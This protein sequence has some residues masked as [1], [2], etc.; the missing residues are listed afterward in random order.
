MA[1]CQP[2]DLAVKPASARIGV[3]GGIMAVATTLAANL[4]ILLVRPADLCRFGPFAALLFDA[5][6]LIVFVLLAAAVGTATG[7]AVGSVGQ[8]TLAGLLFG[9]IAG[10]A[11]L[12]TVPFAPAVTHRLQD[13]N[14]LCP[15]TSAIRGG[16]GG[17]FSFS[18]GP[19]PPP[20]VVPP[21]PPPGF[22]IT[23]PPIGFESSPS[24]VAVAL[25]SVIGLLATVAVGIGL[26]AGTAALGGLIGVAL[27]PRSATS[28]WT[29]E[30]S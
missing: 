2:S 12:L 27:R 6:A 30:G 11:L 25:P 22:F 1:G 19:T 5:A 13:V 21:T 29:P 18:F 10:V 15:Q 26:A 9:V 23:P 3:I 24:G 16:S 7:R 17:S 14:T 20:G 4:W 28:S 8:A